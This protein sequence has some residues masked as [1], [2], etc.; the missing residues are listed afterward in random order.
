MWW[1]PAEHGD[2][3]D[4]RFCLNVQALGCSRQEKAAFGDSRFPPKQKEKH[5]VLL[6]FT[7]FMMDAADEELRAQRSDC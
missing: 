2:E 7:C 4:E 3:L 1:S 6:A 5:S